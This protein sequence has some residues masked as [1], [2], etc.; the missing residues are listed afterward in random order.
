M[1]LLRD[2]ADGVAI[3]PPFFVRVLI[4]GRSTPKYDA[5]PDPYSAMENALEMAGKFGC[6]ILLTGHKNNTEFICFQID[7]DGQ[8]TYFVDEDWL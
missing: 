1:G 4:P 2:P 8:S 6:K 7:E 5:F 3:L